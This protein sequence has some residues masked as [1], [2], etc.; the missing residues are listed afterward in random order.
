LKNSAH[1]FTCLANAKTGSG[2]RIV[3]RR[4]RAFKITGLTWIVERSF[5]WLGRNR[6]LR[7]RRRARR[8]RNGSVD[9]RAR[10]DPHRGRDRS[11]R[12]IVS[13]RPVCRLQNERR[14]AASVVKSQVNGALRR[15]PLPFVRIQGLHRRMIRPA[16][17]IRSPR[18][19]HLQL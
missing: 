16:S 14:R 11:C 7:R 3:K 17:F 12:G 15:T 18:S 10:C 9:D 4:Q 2:S 13:Q 1:C 5:A 19:I 6:R 8:A